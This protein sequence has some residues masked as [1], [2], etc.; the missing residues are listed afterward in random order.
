MEETRFFVWAAPGR[1][2]E[3]LP[4]PP[5][6]IDYSRLSPADQHFEGV[7][8]LLEWWRRW[9]AGELAT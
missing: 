2:S 1:G 4:Q 6:E 9:E 3:A 8:N 5:C 7:R